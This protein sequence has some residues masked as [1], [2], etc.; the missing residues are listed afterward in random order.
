MLS[1]VATAVSPTVSNERTLSSGPS[2][3][4]S[5]SDLPIFRKSRGRTARV[6]TVAGE[7]RS[8]G[9]FARPRLPD[10]ADE[11]WRPKAIPVGTG[12]GS[13][14]ERSTGCGGAWLENQ[15]PPPRHWMAA[16]AS[17]S[18]SLTGLEPAPDRQTGHLGRAIDRDADSLPSQMALVQPSIVIVPGSSAAVL[19]ILESPG[20]AGRQLT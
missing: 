20:L 17:D 7:E 11:K 10:S 13:G 5:G 12:P 14:S 18:D 8:D 3:S 16:S 4:D 2:A 15:G 9:G 1:T 19:R 6:P